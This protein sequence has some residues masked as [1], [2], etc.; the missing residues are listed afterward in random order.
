MTDATAHANAPSMTNSAPGERLRNLHTSAGTAL[1]KMHDIR[2]L[3]SA[4]LHVLGNAKERDHEPLTTAFSLAGM[5]EEQATIEANRIDEI[6]I[7]LYAVC[8]ELKVE[9]VSP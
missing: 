6:S 1:D 5:I 7:G 2:G 3:A 9:N 8:Q 4:L